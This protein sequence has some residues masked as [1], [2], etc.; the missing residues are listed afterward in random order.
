MFYRIR[1]LLMLLAMFSTTALAEQHGQNVAIAPDG[2]VQSFL[3][4]LSSTNAQKQQQNVSSSE[5]EKD[6]GQKLI[7]LQEKAGGAQ[8][9]VRQLLYFGAQ[10]KSTREGMLPWV[11]IE[12]MSISQ[13]DI[14]SALVPC[15]ET[16]DRELLRE[17][18]EWLEG[19]DYDRSAKRYA[20]SSYE[21]VIRDARNAIPQGLVKYMYETSPD[22]AFSCMATVYLDKDEAKTLIDQVKSED[23]VQAVDQLSKRPE[24]W[25]KLYVAEKMKQNPKLRDPELIEQLK[26]SKNPV[27]NA[28]I[29][30]IEDEQK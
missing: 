25:A 13:D 12:Q 18:N 4:A 7:E 23:E 9:L 8:E 24:W 3:K 16:D 29:Q 30:E 26:K 20:F 22:A 14:R 21:K 19:I 17:V 10:S 5:T 28:T 6:L 2:A 27:V 11:I 15:L 1:L